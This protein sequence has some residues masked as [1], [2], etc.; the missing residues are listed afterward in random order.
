VAGVY[1]PPHLIAALPE[2]LQDALLDGPLP[3]KWDV[4]GARLLARVHQLTPGPRF[5]GGEAC[6]RFGGVAGGAAPADPLRQGGLLRQ[7]PTRAMRGAPSAG[8]CVGH[9]AARGPACGT[10][11]SWRAGDDSPSLRASAGSGTGRGVLLPA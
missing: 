11:A 6:G 2:E 10:L 5:A 1:W 3:A 7:A 4:D 9:F 8:R